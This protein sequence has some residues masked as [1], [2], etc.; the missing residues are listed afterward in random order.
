MRSLLVFLAIAAVACTGN[1]DTDRD[2]NPI[3]P[4][5]ADAGTGGAADGPVTGGSDAAPGA[6]PAAA[7]CATG[8]EC[9]GGTC[10]G[11]PGQPE[12][13]N[14]RFTGGYCTATGCTPNTQEGCGADEF[15]VETGDPAVLGGGYC[16]EIC[17]K[18]DG[19]VCDRPDHVCLGLGF[20]GGCFSQDIVECDRK[21]KTGCQEGEI[22]VKIGFEDDSPLG[23]CET[24][25]DPV[26]DWEAT[27]GADR[28]CYYIR[29]YN[30]SFC[31]LEGKSLPEETCACDKCCV[32]GYAC[33]PDLDGTGRHCK[34]YCTVADPKEC[35]EGEVCEPIEEPNEV[36]D[37]LSPVGGC[38]AP[39]SAGT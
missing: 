5:E 33:T 12:A 1:G 31:G 28:A 39:G 30:A 17:S 22:C 35:A 36:R 34:K 23:R 16:V 37:W 24:A 4:G 18:A 26:G 29:A 13:E 20:L 32:P 19:L 38:I 6:K 27:C 10:L 25:C 7:A 11:A 9:A 21:E 3:Q 15:C 2:P 14:D 8:A